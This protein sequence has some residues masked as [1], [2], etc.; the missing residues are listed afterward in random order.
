MFEGRGKGQG[1]RGKGVAGLLSV[2]VCAL[3]LVVAAVPGQASDVRD[4]TRPPQM[5]HHVNPAPVPVRRDYVLQSTRVAGDLRSA[6][7]NGR[8]VSAGDRVDGA[9]VVAVDVARVRLRDHHGEFTLRLAVPEI[10]RPARNTSAP[11]EARP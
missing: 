5:S 7:I 9:L 3:V 11:G 2:I 8:V 6:V 4:P 1:A 10:A